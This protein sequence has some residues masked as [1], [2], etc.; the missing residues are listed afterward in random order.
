MGGNVSFQGEF[1]WPDEFIRSP[2]GSKITTFARAT[3]LL[4]PALD[5]A[6]ASFAGYVL[7]PFFP[8]MKM[9]DHP[10]HLLWNVQGYKI[11]SLD[12]LPSDYLAAA[13]QDF[14]DEFEQSPEFDPEPSGFAQ[15]LRAMGR[16]P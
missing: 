11:G 1:E 3:D 8:W 12:A 15:R 10:G 16:L 6:P 4:D 14:G 13:A 2:A 7:M 5:S 9:A